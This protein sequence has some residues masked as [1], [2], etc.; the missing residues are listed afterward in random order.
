MPGP[1]CGART[2]P[3]LPRALVWHCPSSHLP[4]H[5]TAVLPRAL[6][7]H[8]CNHHLFPASSPPRPSSA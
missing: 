2:P 8:K 1:L 5:A 4:S 7:M 3:Q 6:G